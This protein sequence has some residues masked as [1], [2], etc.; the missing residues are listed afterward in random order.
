MGPEIRE[1][2]DCPEV[3]P[4]I[5]AWHWPEWAGG[6]PDGTLAGLQRLF[7]SWIHRDGLPCI[8]VAF[9]ADSP[10]GSVAL[11]PHDMEAPESRLASL[12]PWL[13][14]LYVIPDAR[15]EGAGSSLVVACEHRAASLGYSDLFLYTQT[16]EDF[17]L[18]RGWVTIANTDYEAEAI[19]VMQRSFVPD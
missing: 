10:I 7:A 12:T 16:A 13:S 2:A 11:V 6:S 8:F 17:Y 5:A 14:G 3:A 15:R 18:R 9:Q 1:L 4:T 19:V